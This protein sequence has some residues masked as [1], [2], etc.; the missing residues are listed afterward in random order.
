MVENIPPNERGIESY[1]NV[2]GGHAYTG[3][4]VQSIHCFIRDFHADLMAVRRILYFDLLR[5][6]EKCTDLADRSRTYRWCKPMAHRLIYSCTVNRR[7]DE[8]NGCSGRRGIA[9]IF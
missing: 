7:S 1:P 4:A 3:M 6:I 9:E 8:S 2:T 5:C